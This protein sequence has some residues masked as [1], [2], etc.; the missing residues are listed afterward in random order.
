M[1]DITL[2]H[3]LSKEAFAAKD[4]DLRNR[5]LAFQQRLA[6]EAAP[7]LVVVCGMDGSGRGKLISELG[8]RMNPRLFR[9]HAFWER[10]RGGDRKPFYARFWD[11]LPA[12]GTTAIHVGAWYDALIDK[13]ADG[14][15]V[16][17]ELQAVAEFEE[18][19]A[20]NGTRILKIWAHLDKKRQKKRLKDRRE[21]GETDKKVMKA[22]LKRLKAYNKTARA[23]ETVLS[24]TH[25]AF[26]PW[27]VIDASDADWLLMETAEAVLSAGTP[28]PVGH[29][30]PPEPAPDAPTLNIARFPT[31]DEAEY[32]QEKS[33]LQGR[34][35]ALA[36]KA[37]R[38]G[39]SPVL[40]FEGWDAGGKGGTIRR[41]TEALDARLWT[42]FGSSA[43]NDLEKRHH[44]LWRYWKTLPP[45]GFMAVYDRSWYGRVLV[46]RV[47]GFA[48]T[49]AWQRAYRE[50]NAF[51]HHLA[52]SGAII[53]KFWL[54]ISPD[55]QKR[56]FENREEVE[57]KN[58]KITDE[59]WRNRE[60]WAAYE[61]AAAEMFARTHTAHAPWQVVPAED[62]HY[63][64]IHVLRA[65]A[66]RL[67]AELG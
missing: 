30:P 2:G 59:D 61:T 63:G 1:L 28:A 67:E 25:T 43:P 56:R 3:S 24:A 22:K 8:A 60:R 62:K 26:A 36:W 6:E 54:H 55:E 39:R 53:L 29:H 27:H 42:V 4:A 40:V 52:D 15:D 5:L 32:K 57:Y 20:A 44:Y 64:R 17:T 49:E 16:G 10:D 47:E 66:D 34:L 12:A 7:L 45:A 13:A 14:D 50:I 18:T 33:R 46:E 37:Y 51:E 23:A 38:K 11:A 65:V 9:I 21:R 41:L 19:L 48:D 31:L 58:Y 35:S